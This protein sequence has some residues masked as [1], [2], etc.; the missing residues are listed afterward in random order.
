METNQILSQKYSIQYIVAAFC[1]NTSID[2]AWFQ[3]KLVDVVRRH[4]LATDYIENPFCGI[5]TEKQCQTDYELQAVHHTYLMQHR[6]THF[7]FVESGTLTDDLCQYAIEKLL[8]KRSQLLDE[9]MLERDER[10]LKKIKTELDSYGF[11]QEAHDKKVDDEWQVMLHA[12]DRPIPDIYYETEIV[13]ID[14]EQEALEHAAYVD[15]LMGPPDD[16][17]ET[18]SSEETALANATM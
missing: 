5:Q 6:I 10:E 7:P 18:M 12:V 15:A 3:E 8:D 16:Y 1:H 11:D 17:S 13:S 2:K 14:E 4:K 9:P